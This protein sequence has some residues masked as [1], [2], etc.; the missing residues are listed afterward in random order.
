MVYGI[1]LCTYSDDGLYRWSLLDGRIFQSRDD[2]VEHARQYTEDRNWNGNVTFSDDHNW[3]WRR[4]DNDGEMD[5]LCLVDG[6]DR[7]GIVREI[8]NFG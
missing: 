8:R 7:A 6:E 1:A 3:N 5:D 4:E 2:A